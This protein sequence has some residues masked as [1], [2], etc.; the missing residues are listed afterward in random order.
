MR[1]I[2]VGD[3]LEWNDESVL[4]KYDIMGERRYI[5]VEKI[6]ECDS[7]GPGCDEMGCPGEI[8]GECYGASGKR[9]SNLMCLK[10]GNFNVWKGKKR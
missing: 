4:N 1:K 7:R 10:L 3:H 8:N 2:R 6:T 5:L 9:V